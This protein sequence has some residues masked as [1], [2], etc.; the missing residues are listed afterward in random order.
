M[1]KKAFV[2]KYFIITIF[3][4]LFTIMSVNLIHYLNGIF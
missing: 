2:L 4:T 3:F 1:R